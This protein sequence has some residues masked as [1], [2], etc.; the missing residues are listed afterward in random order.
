MDMTTESIAW[1]A[2]NR[3]PQLGG[4]RCLRLTEH[5]GSAAAALQA[6]VGAWEEIVGPVVAGQARAQELDRGW[7][8]DQLKSLEQRGGHLIPISH[9]D[10]PPLLLETPHPPAVLHVLGET[11]LT[12]AAVAIVGT[13]NPTDYGCAVARQLGR[14]LAVRGFCVVSGMA[15]GIDAAAHQGALEAGGRTLAVLGCGV[16]VA[17]PHE[18]SNL[19]MRIQQQGAVFSEFPMGSPPDKG[20]FPRR[21]RLIS[22]LSLGVV[23]VEA[24]ARSGALITARYAR[25]QNR[26]VFAV[27]GD[28]RTHKSAGCHQLIRDG[29]ILVEGVEDVVEELQHWGLGDQ[30]EVEPEVA[31]VSEPTAVLSSREQV[32]LERLDTE[33]CHIDRLSQEVDLETAE[34][35]GTLLELELTGLVEQLPGKRF[36]RV[37]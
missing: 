17:Y 16:D 33:P 5:F 15:R 4:K 11:R 18:N 2:L 19:Y 24:P 32:I 21:N 3:L 8:A 1:L 20:W 36:I 34:V 29:A 35:L 7:A 6:S 37:Y 22:G 23:L 28:V 27:P 31:A 12:T 9:P 10:F 26:E 13:R 14:A 25:E 30:R